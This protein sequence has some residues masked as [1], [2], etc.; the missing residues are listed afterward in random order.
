[1][2]FQI[3]GEFELVKTSE[4]KSIS[5]VLGSGGARGLA[6]IGIITELQN[7]GFEIKSI[8]GAS[9]GALVGGV[10][11]CGKLEEFTDWVQ[12]I[13]KFNVLNLLDISWTPGGLLKGDKLF[14]VVAPLVGD[15][16]IEDL[17]IKFTAVATDITKEKEVWTNSGSLF[18]AIRESISLPMVMTPVHRDNMILVD[19]GVLNPVPIGPTLNDRTDLTIA[20]NL[21]GVPVQKTAHDMGE[22]ID[23]NANEKFAT[24]INSFLKDLGVGKASR[25]PRKNA[26]MSMFE[27]MDRSFDVMQNC[28]ARQKMAA[29]APDYLINIPRNACQTMDFHRASEMIE[30]GKNSACKIIKQISTG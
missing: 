21:G 5:L 12:A 30:L 17:P 6:H 11:A 23:K 3:I 8:A 15:R 9:M 29:N 20:V 13:T 7:A 24:R 2:K 16:N 26:D 18:A 1:V 19:G 25:T 14:E 22:Q 10:F 28:I 4:A 27:V